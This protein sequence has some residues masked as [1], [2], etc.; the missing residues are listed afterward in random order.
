VD[1]NECEAS[2]CVNGGT[3]VNEPGSYRYV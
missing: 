1:V 2:P 3:C